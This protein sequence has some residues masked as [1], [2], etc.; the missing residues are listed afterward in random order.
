VPNVLPLPT[1]VRDSRTPKAM[2]LK[3]IFCIFCGRKSSFNLC[4]FLGYCGAIKESR[5][6]LTTYG[7]FLI[8]ILCLQ[9][10][11]YSNSVAEPVYFC[12][13][14]ASVCHNFGSSTLFSV[15]R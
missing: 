14:P 10:E 9:V 2:F 6:L 15:F 3:I 11:S 12:A 1:A 4:S 7:V 13:A 5:V 8:I